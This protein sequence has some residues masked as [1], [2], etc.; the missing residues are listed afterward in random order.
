MK[1]VFIIFTAAAIAAC[2]LPLAACGNGDNDVSRYDVSV[3]FDQSKNCLSGTVSLDYLNDTETEIS[4]LK[5]NLW[6]NAYRQNAKYSPVS[7]AYNAKAYYAGASYGDMSVENV[8]NCSGWT[9]DGEDENIL[10]VNLS[11]PVY[12]DEKVEVTITYTVNLAKVNHRLGVTE[13]TVNL[14]NFYPVLCSRTQAGF[15]ETPYYSCGDPFVSVCADYTVSLTV[16]KEYGAAA[17][18]KLVSE[19][20]AGGNK[21]YKYELECAR[22]FAIVLSD[23]FQTLTES[24]DG[25]PVTYYY[26]DDEDAQASLK[27]ATESL[28]YFSDSYGKYAYP[29]LSVVQTG[30]CMGGMEYPALTMISDDCDKDTAAYT[31]VHENAHQWWYAMVGSDQVNCGWQDEGLAEYSTMN[32]F[33]SK[34]EYGFTRTGMLGMATKSYRAFYSVYNQIFGKTDTSM[35]RCLKDYVSDYEY[36]N[37]AYNKGMLM[38]EAVRVAMGDEKFNAALKEYCETNKFGIASPEALMAPFV[39]RAD[40]QGIFNSFLEGKVIL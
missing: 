3:V 2:A 14:G 7:E 38:F 1:K 13:N 28:K 31:I 22:D 5:F 39:K 11:E 25:V 18:G 6:G 19:N 34:P 27:A 20:A 35:S 36:V 4:D 21:T 32:F 17:S 15:D 8:E 24:V 37:I 16:P 29:T 40:V 12:P 33:E 23:K 9:I 26:Y 10:T 30:F